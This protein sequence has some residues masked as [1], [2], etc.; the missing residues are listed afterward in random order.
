[1]EL[2][3]KNRV[4]RLTLNGELSIIHVG[5]YKQA[6]VEALP[7]FDDLTLVLDGV[8]AI[9]LAFIQLLFS[10]RQSMLAQQ[11]PIHLEGRPEFFRLFLAKYGF[12]SEL[13]HNKGETQ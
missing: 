8:T 10:L 12:D 3:I 1:M 6:L 9:D 5:E 4:A 2:S 11:K 13:F 7:K